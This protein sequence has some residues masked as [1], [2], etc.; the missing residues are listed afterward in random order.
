[1]DKITNDERDQLTDLIAHMIQIMERIG[2]DF[3]EHVKE[4]HPGWAPKRLAIKAE[5]R[6]IDES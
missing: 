5:N 4:C 6:I 1:M 2:D 3:A